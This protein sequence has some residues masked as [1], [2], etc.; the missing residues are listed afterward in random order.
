[1]I[2]PNRRILAKKEK[3]TEPRRGRGKRREEETV[4]AAVE[5]RLVLCE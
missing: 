2:H 5:V 3:V 1:M 4:A